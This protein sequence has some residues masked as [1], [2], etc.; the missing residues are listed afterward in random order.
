MA[1]VRARAILGY[2]CGVE[3][4]GRIECKGREGTGVK[5]G[6][7]IKVQDGGPVG[8]LIAAAHHQSVE[9]LGSVFAPSGG[10]N[11]S[12][13]ICG[14]GVGHRAAADDVLEVIHRAPRLGEG[15]VSEEGEREG[16]RQWMRENSTKQFAP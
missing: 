14:E 11:V 13:S 6:K 2:A 16:E 10:V 7:I 5:A 15:G 3:I 8:A 12:L 1:V 9:R 4:L